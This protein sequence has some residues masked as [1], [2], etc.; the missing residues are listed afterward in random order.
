M[1][2]SSGT[3]KPERMFTIS[4]PNKA[5]PR[6][7]SMIGNARLRSR[8]SSHGVGSFV[9][10]MRA[11]D[12]AVVLRSLETLAPER[13]SARRLSEPPHSGPSSPTLLRQRILLRLHVHPEAVPPDAGYHL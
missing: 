9:S 7:M 10:F 5:R 2:S 13:I 6:M 3:R 4:T 8:G 12:P 1:C 11:E